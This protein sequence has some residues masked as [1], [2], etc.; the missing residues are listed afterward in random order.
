LM[1]RAGVAIWRNR[2]C[3]PGGVL[4]NFVRF[5]VIMPLI[6]VLDAATFIGTLQWAVKDKSG[7]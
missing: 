2:F 6:A 3:Y 1:A 7:R 4:E 5:L